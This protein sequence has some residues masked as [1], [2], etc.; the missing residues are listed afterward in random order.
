[1][2]LTRKR[3]RYCRYILDCQKVF[4]ELTKIGL[5]KASSARHNRCQCDRSPIN[6]SADYLKSSIFERMSA[7]EWISRE[8]IKNFI[9]FYWI[10]FLLSDFTFRKRKWSIYEVI[11]EKRARSWRQNP[12]GVE[13]LPSEV[14]SC[15]FGPEHC[16]ICPVISFHL[17]QLSL[18]AKPRGEISM[19]FELGI[20]GFAGHF[21]RWYLSQGTRARNSRLIW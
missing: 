6:Y 19:K 10:T 1:M 5:F 15:T 18:P 12:I 14:F 21:T 7:E 13:R 8:H 11:F 9:Y 17:T 2:I 20:D 16:L 3:K 4:I